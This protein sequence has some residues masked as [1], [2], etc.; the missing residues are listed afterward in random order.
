MKFFLRIWAILTTLPGRFIAQWGLVLAAILGLVTS[1]SLIISIPL[2]SD[3]VYSQTLQ[4]KVLQ[5]D[6]TSLRRPAYAFLFQFY[7]GWSGVKQWE[8]IQPADNYITNTA[9]R[10]LGLPLEN[11]V[12]FSKTDSFPLFPM[13]DKTVYK[14]IRSILSWGSF[15]FMSDIQDHIN[16]L[17]GQFPGDYNYTNDSA[18]GIMVSETMA[19]QLGLQIGEEYVALAKTDTD[20]G[21]TVTIEIP[22]KIVGVWVPKEVS[23]GYW[24]F[25]PDNLET[26]MLVSE[27]SFKD[28]I[29]AAIP[30]EIYSFY[31]YLVMDGNAVHADQVGSLLSRIVTMQAKVAS[32]LEGTKLSVSPVDALLEYQRAAGLL[33]ILLYA[34]SIPIFG[35]VLAFI[36]LVARLQVERQRNE[37]AVLRSRGATP[38]Q[39]LTVIILEGL[40]TGL[41]AL[42]ISLPVGIQVA[43]FIGQTRSFLDFSANTDLQVSMTAGAI[44]TGLIAIGIALVAM[45][46]PAVGAARHTIVSYKSETSRPVT[47]PWW[48]RS[49]MDVLLFIPAAYGA[50]LLRQQGSLTLMGGASTG[51]PFSNPLLF[52]VPALGIFA[53]T[54]FCLRLIRPVMAAIA[55]LASWTRNIG[56]LLAARQFSRVPGAYNTPL[57]ILVLTLSLSSYTA[58]LARTLDH[59][60]YDQMYYKI[61]SDVRFVDYGDVTARSGSSG[62][63]GG[64]P[65][66]QE[67]TSSSETAVEG[68]PQWMFF[69][70]SEYLKIDDVTAA[71]RMGRYVAEPEL[72]TG[73]SREGL[74]IGIDRLDFP[75]V[76][77]WRDDFANESLGG[78][79]NRL[80]VDGANVLVSR[81]FLEQNGI[82]VGD[83]LRLVVYTYGEPHRLELR[84]AGSVELFP[85]WY[86][87]KDGPLFVGNLDYLYEQAGNEFPYQVLLKTDPNIDFV[88]FST[89]GVSKIGATLLNWDATPI[90]IQ[91]EQERPE[92]QGLFGLLFIG[93][94]AAAILTVISFLLYV[95]FSFQRRFVELGVLRASGL[96]AGQM[97]A[98]LTWELVM[99]ILFGGGIGTGLGVWASKLFIPYLQIGADTT[100]RIPPFKVLIAWNEIFLIYAVFSALFLVTLVILGVILRRMKIFQAIKLG[101]A[102]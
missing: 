60:L 8:D 44:R 1:V 50:Y 101:E 77:F 73:G 74:F 46:I 92:R 15:T 11:Y 23:D 22:V 28:Y 75:L 102:V 54:L 47:A 21:A 41:I 5:Q 72:A 26:S 24:M 39:V 97:T 16:I 66:G 6:A 43:H 33:T 52:L 89:V 90:V 31:W 40:I 55:W 42:A 78:L 30:N 91:K 20:T 76:S 45:I 13:G 99:F 48:Q 38:T 95:L 27:N 64:S 85:T 56:L 18:I 35:L 29:G 79:M 59:H 36:S 14:D 88:K 17:E 98:Y 65:S 12:R 80:A 69:P 87:E 4:N 37:I 7:G 58:S 10:Q 51:D 71:V 67:Q 100:A 32:L 63:P 94:A 25:H 83:I 49:F 3:A 84:V 19:T 81:V 86:P 34:F 68:A 53:L 9:P 96:S 70:V 2:Y 57:I 62:S 61:G 93:F 82:K